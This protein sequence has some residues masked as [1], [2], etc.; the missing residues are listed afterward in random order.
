[1]CG[2]RCDAVLCDG[3]RDRWRRCVVKMRVASGGLELDLVHEGVQPGQGPRYA[4][5]ECE[6]RGT[7]ND[8]NMA[9]RWDHDAFSLGGGLVVQWSPG[10]SKDQPVILRASR[11]VSRRCI[12]EEENVRLGFVDFVVLPT[13]TL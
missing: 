10:A 6:I 2:L 12:L 13:Q 7:T 8:L 3:R 1:M 4:V 9:A 5:V 11:T